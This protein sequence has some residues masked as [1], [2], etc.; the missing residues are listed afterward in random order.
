MEA[1]PKGLGGVGSPSQGLVGQK[2]FPEGREGSRGPLGKPEGVIRPFQRD[3]KVWEGRE[4]SGVP[5][6]ELGCVRRPSWRDGRG[7]EAL[8]KGAGRVGRPSE[9]AGKGRK[10][11]Q[12][13]E[14]GRED[15]PQG[16]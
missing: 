5:P 3:G 13:G 11:L 4:R 9:R 1:L 14:W 12:E 15:L 8:S 2:A 16:R 7:W 10:A 6:R